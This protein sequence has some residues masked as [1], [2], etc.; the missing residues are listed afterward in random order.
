ML[1]RS[2]IDRMSFLF[3]FASNSLIFFTSTS[4]FSLTHFFLCFKILSSF[5]IHLYNCYAMKSFA[6]S[7]RQS[8][9]NVVNWDVTHKKNMTFI[10]QEINNQV[11]IHIMWNTCTV[12]IINVLLLLIKCQSWISL[13][14]FDWI[15]SSHMTIDF[16]YCCCCCCSMLHFMVR[17]VCCKQVLLC[18]SLT[19]II[20][21]IIK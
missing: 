12:C 10:S 15:K 8:K 17:C 11:C 13:N 5:Y 6:Y 14:N 1:K 21:G 2:V 19:S 7:M 9:I 20:N 16:F 4:H 18:E 3:T